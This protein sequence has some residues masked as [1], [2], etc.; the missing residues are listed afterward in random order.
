MSASP[1]TRVLVVQEDR[2][3]RDSMVSVL[4]ELGYEVQ[5]V[6]DGEA[7]MGEL[8]A[9]PHRLPAVIVCDMTM[10]RMDGRRLR[11]ELMRDPA[12]AEESRWSC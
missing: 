2:E 9:A 8:R 1:P 7:A 12:L 6:S 5:S 3:A 4:S 10:P 11:H